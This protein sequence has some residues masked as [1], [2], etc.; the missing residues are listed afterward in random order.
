[1]VRRRDAAVLTIRHAVSLEQLLIPAPK[2]KSSKRILVPRNKQINKQTNK[3]PSA[4]FFIARMA[5]MQA[6]IRKQYRKTR[7]CYT[8]N[9][10][11]CSS[12]VSIASKRIHSSLNSFHRLLGAYFVERY[13]RYKI[14][15]GTPSAGTLNIQG[16]KN[17]HFGPNFAVYIGNGTTQAHDYYGSVIG[18]HVTHL[19]HFQ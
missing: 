6:Y 7:Y 18:N 12:R 19:C 14:P 13:R 11:V 4:V 8:P 10:P 9:L 1:V 16:G 2:S 3:R 15:G 5:Y 17:C